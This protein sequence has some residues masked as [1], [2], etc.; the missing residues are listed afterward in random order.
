MKVVNTAQGTILIN[1]LAFLQSFCCTETHARVCVC[2]SQMD[3][4]V[5]NVVL[6]W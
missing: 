1:F 2:V 6:V 5:G 4:F 3:T